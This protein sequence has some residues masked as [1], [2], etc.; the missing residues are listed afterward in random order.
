MC[1]W[2]FV[3]LFISMLFAVLAQ[4]HNDVDGEIF[5]YDFVR[6]KSIFFLFQG[7]ILNVQ[8]ALRSDLELIERSARAQ[9][10]HALNRL[11]KKPVYNFAHLF[12]NNF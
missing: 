6:R 11:L 9:R 3:I 2:F 10:L 5:R 4:M 8:Q 1:R 12:K 7:S